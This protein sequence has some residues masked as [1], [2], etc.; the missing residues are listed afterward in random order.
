MLPPEIAKLKNIRQINLYGNPLDKA[1]FTEFLK[2]C[3]KKVQ[4][5]EHV[6]K[7]DNDDNSV[8]RIY[9]EKI[10]PEWEKLPNVEVIR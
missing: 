4:L 7:S 10:E 8:L 5:T 6:Y 1:K 2:S 9:V 3:T